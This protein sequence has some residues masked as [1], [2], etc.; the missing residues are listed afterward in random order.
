M[1]KRISNTN[2]KAM[3]VDAFLYD[4]LGG[5][6]AEF[7]AK[8]D[9]LK[10]NAGEEG[11]SGQ[12]A[13]SLDAIIDKRKV[14]EST[15]VIVSGEMVGLASVFGKQLDSMGLAMSFEANL[16]AKT[17][18]TGVARLC[19]NAFTAMPKG[20]FSMTV[21]DMSTIMKIADSSTPD[22]TV[23]SKIDGLVLRISTKINK[24][25]ERLVYRLSQD[26][27]VKKQELL[28]D[29][30]FFDNN[31]K[32][33]VYQKNSTAKVHKIGQES[34]PLAEFVFE[35]LDDEDEE[36]YPVTLKDKK[37]GF[38]AGT[39]FIKINYKPIDHSLLSPSWPEKLRSAS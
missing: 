25:G 5:K 29:S 35:N 7:N 28:F 20:C 36:L 22:N 9:E 32:I 21:E 19:C 34:I 24:E 6:M 17:S 2:I 37:T 16:D 4:R 18:I 27:L 13:M 8:A 23:L 3:G 10:K 39:L 31:I 30:C 38:E 33:E 14:Y 15:R 12:A 1:L 11:E 26:E